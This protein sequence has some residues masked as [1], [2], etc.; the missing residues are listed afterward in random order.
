MGGTHM[1]RVDHVTAPF[2]HIPKGTLF[3]LLWHQPGTYIKLDERLEKN[4]YINAAGKNRP[5]LS[6]GY[7]WFFGDIIVHILAWP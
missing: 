5:G 6:R 3:T 7:R 2:G 4:G 1:Q